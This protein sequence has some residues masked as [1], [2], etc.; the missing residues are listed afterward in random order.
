VT[1]QTEG[2]VAFVITLEPDA[3]PGYP[4]ALRA[5]VAYAV[6][7]AGLTCRF[8]VEN[9]GTDPAPVAVGFHPYFTVGSERIDT[10]TLTL[11]FSA[12]LEFQNL[13]PT[14]HR[15]HVAAIFNIAIFGTGAAIYLFAVDLIMNTASLPGWLQVVLVWLVGVVG[16][17]LLRPYRRITQ[18]GGR[19]P[20]ATIH[21]GPWTTP[22]EYARPPQTRGSDRAESSPHALGALENARSTS[23]IRSRG[24]RPSCKQGYPTTAPAS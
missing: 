14:A 6:D 19:D 24:G 21:S 18:L 3:H 22:P 2:G 11:P 23:G 7:A 9:I 4:F 17:L 16:W 13:I 12:S 1:H 10:D 8:T 5:T 20:A 15:H